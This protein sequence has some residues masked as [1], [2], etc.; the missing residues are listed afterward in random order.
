MT[1]E[2]YEER[3]SALEERHRADLDLMNEAHEARMRSLDELWRAGG[4]ADRNSAGPEPSPDR[5]AAAPEPAPKPARPPGTVLEDLYEAFADLPEIFDK[6]DIIRILGYEPA[7]ATLY[8]ALT[9]LRQEGL[10]ANDTYSAGGT[11]TR[12]RKLGPPD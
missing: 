12:Y 1:R 7:R 11:T 3:R 9:A 5:Q 2:E 6:R 4:A 8:R 10:I